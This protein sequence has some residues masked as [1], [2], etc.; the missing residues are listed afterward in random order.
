MKTRKMGW[1]DL[2]L[3]AV[4]LGTFAIGGVGWAASWGPQ[5]DKDSID[6]I[7]RSLDLG[8]NWLDTAPIYGFG[9]AEEVVGRALKG[10]SKKPIIA[11][12]CGLL[13]GEKGVPINHLK[14]KS[15]LAEAEASLKRLGID[16][17]DIYFVHWPIPDEDI[18]EAWEAIAQ[19]AKQGKV[20]WAA[21]SNFSV[22][23][24][25]R[26]QPIHPVAVLESSYSMI[27]RD[28]EEE[29]MGYCV[30][31]KIAIVPW[32]PMAHGLL[33]GRFSRER[34]QNLDKDDGFRRNISQHF[35][36]P[37][38][39]ANLELVEK[40]RPIA[41]RND[42]TLA[43]LAVAWVLRRPEVTSAI[44]GARKPTQIEETAVAGDWALSKKDTNEIETLL[45]ERAKKLGAEK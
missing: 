30:K 18:E 1:T 31:N 15:I 25:E 20:R 35:Q 8:I 12:K 32:G 39:S 17:I 27:E 5:D 24:L 16:T 11:T 23:Q 29:I 34:V 4:G 22:A 14:K 38:L 9:H 26:V 3:T 7:R 42:R 19:L 36:E 40:L 2:E 33:T 44:V 28:L 10:L 21:A 45:A 43:Q 41:Q 13:P 6:T 37:Q